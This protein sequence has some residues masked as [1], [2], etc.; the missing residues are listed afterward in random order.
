MNWGRPFQYLALVAQ[1]ILVATFLWIF[2]IVM[3]HVTS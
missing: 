1:L 2:T 3:N